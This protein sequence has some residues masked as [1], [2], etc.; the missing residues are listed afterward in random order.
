MSDIGLANLQN[1]YTFKAKRESGTISAPVTSDFSK[2]NAADENGKQPLPAAL[3]E[4]FTVKEPELRAAMEHL[5]EMMRNMQRELNFSVDE[6]SGKTVVR[7]IDAETQ[8]VIRQIPSEEAMKLAQRVRESLADEGL[9][10]DSV[11]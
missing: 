9:L 10:V 5:D 11:V 2:R 3:A 7:I 8:E 4:P 1:I 6:D